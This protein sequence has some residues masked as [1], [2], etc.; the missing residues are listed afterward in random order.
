MVAKLERIDGT[1]AKDGGIYPSDWTAK[2]WGY[3]GYGQLDNGSYT[4]SNITVDVL[5]YQY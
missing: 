4:H 3:N 2:C 1:A 5:N